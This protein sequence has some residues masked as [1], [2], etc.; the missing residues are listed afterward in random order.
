MPPMSPKP[1]PTAHLLVGPVATHAINQFVKP[2]IMERPQFIGTIAAPTPLAE[3][4]PFMS[5]ERKKWAQIVK[6]EGIN[7]GQ[8]C[9]AEMVCLL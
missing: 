3:C 5:A 2:E 8:L 1:N 6:A 9:S 4:V 7:Q